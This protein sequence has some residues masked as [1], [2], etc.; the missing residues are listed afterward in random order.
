MAASR[1]ILLMPAVFRALIFYTV[2]GVDRRVDVT[3]VDRRVA[4]GCFGGVNV[5]GCVCV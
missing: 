2:T 3:G 5:R 1:V 4:L